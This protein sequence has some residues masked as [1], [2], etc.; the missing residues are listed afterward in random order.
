M[1]PVSPQRQPRILLVISSL[2]AGGSERVI[3]EM[4][5]WWAA[6]ERDV[7]VLILEKSYSD[8]YR[9][10]PG[11]E[12]ITFDWQLPRTRL[13]IPTQYIKNKIML[14]NT[15]LNYMPDVLISFVDKTNIRMLFHLVG[16]GIPHIAAERVDPR[17][18]HIELSWSLARRLLYPFSN[19]L[20]VQTNSV[21]AWANR[22]VPRNK[23]RVIPNFVRTMPEPEEMIKEEG[24]LNPFILT[25]GRLDKQKGHDLLIRAFAGIEAKRRGWRLVILGEG[26]ERS[27][28]EKL[29]GNL[30]ISDM[31]DM[32]GIVREPAEWLYK[33]RFFV[34]P[35]RFEG[36]PNALLEAMACA[37]AVIAA[38]CPSGPAEII[39]HNENGLL[40][41]KEDVEALRAA[42]S[43]L[44]EDEG[45]R[46]RLGQQ[47]LKV[48]SRFSQAT[49][50]AQWDDLIDSICI[51]KE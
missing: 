8:H 9:L 7:A 3:S 43:R 35:S 34:L 14:R 37:C 38:D 23:V 16:S 2:S 31:V 10:H 22:V 44:M 50:M 13:H 6:H 26:P 41:P 47:A 48:R 32:P 24:R 49:I 19:A 25:V 15:V 18:H 46:T 30:G 29:A 42:I 33:T 27:N 40:V 39:S 4:A 17:Y 12:R 51:S 45:L 20:V 21:T 5:N 1:N 11:V 28:L 36:F